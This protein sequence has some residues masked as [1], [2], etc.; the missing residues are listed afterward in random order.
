MQ[1]C[2]EE[3]NSKLCFCL[4]SFSFFLCFCVSKSAYGVDSLIE[5]EYDS[6]LV[7]LQ[8]CRPNSNQSFYFETLGNLGSA[9]KFQNEIQFG[10]FFF[11]T[12]VNQYRVFQ[13]SENRNNVSLNFNTLSKLNYVNGSKKEQNFSISHKQRISKNVGFG[14]DFRSA[15]SD[16]FYNKQ[17][18]SIRN[19]DIYSRINT[20]D[21]RYNLLLNYVSNRIISQENGGLINDNTFENAGSFDSKVVGIKLD[22]VFNR[23]KS[24][25][26]FLKQ[27]YNFFFLSNDSSFATESNPRIFLI[28]EMRYERGADL[29]TADKFYSD[30]FENAYYDT[31]QTY[32]SSFVNNFCNSFSLHS[33]KIKMLDNLL[34]GNAEIYVKGM[35]QSFDYFQKNSDT[36]MTDLAVES[37]FKVSWNNGLYFDLFY[38]KH[39]NNLKNEYY[40]VGGSVNLDDTLQQRSISI[41]LQQSRKNPDYV[42]SFFNSNHFIWTNQF[43]PINFSNIKIKGER[44]IENQS[45]QLTA[46]YTSIEKLTYFNTEALPA[47]YNGRINIF[48]FKIFHTIKFGN[49]N[50]INSLQIQHVDKEEYLRLPLFS[51]YTSFYFEKILFK[52][53]LTSQYG[54]DIRYCTLYYADAYM[55]ATGQFYLQDEK[56]IGNYPYIDIFMNF[57]IQKFKFFFKL[58]HVNAGFTKRTYYTVP[59]YPMPGRTFKFGIT[60]NFFD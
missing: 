20:A 38:R 43:D 52:N 31:T 57:K 32:D 18:A 24:K 40:D 39:F 10:D 25:V 23:Q 35:H 26:F 7:G 3:M 58:E 29:F 59:H 48:D 4:I 28:H 5:N 41:S 21:R 11:N 22:N 15:N 1:L 9:V 44:K 2:I 45:F 33:S 46:N 51:S 6:S 53:A 30:F 37:G 56:K 12:G 60:W 13:Y 17:K 54:T 55:P 19:F 36:L 42:F 50:L 47:Q 14:L 27:E 16:G 49:F 8:N 34:N